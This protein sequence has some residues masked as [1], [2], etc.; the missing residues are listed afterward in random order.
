MKKYYKAIN[1]TIIIILG[2]TLIFLS[3]GIIE[4]SKINQKIEDFISRSIYLYEN[5][6]YTYYK[7]PRKYIYEETDKILNSPED[8]FVGTTGD[9]YL[10]NRNP[11]N[12]FFLTKWISKMSYIGHGGMVYS[13]DGSQ[14]IEITGNK[15]R[16]EN[17]VKVIDNTWLTIDSPNY[18]IL[19]VKD[20]N[21]TKRERLVQEGNKIIGKRYNYTFISNKNSFYCTDM[22]S[23][24]F[25]RIDVKLNNDSFFT[26]GSDIITDDDTY[27]IYY[28]EKIFKND[29]VHY[30]IYYMSE[31]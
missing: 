31:E 29:K 1:I 4:K 16:K 20:I 12:G 3:D 28:R 8:K 22:I 27:I 2:L 11:I 21:D 19:R 25:N 23:Y 13:N 26:T 24:L 15:G 6:M 18:V 9:I 5:E 14:M 10:S 30:N 7:V 17:I